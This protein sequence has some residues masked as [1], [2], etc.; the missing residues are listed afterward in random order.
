MT[1]R[2]ILVILY[3]VFQAYGLLLLLSVILSWFGSESNR[4]IRLI[5]RAGDWY[6]GLFRGFI[7]IGPL[8]LSTILG[9]IVYQGITNLLIG[10][11]FI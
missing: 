7:V 9:F 11:P 1:L 2:V 10:I 5:R 4:F 8:D 3:Y 6:L